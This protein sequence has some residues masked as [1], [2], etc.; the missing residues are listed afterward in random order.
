MPINTDDKN[1]LEYGLA[2]TLGRQNLFSMKELREAA[3]RLEDD[4]LPLTGDV[5]WKRVT[6]ERLFSW[7]AE[8]EEIPLQ[9]SLDQDQQLRLAALQ[10]YQLGH[11]NEAIQLW[12]S[13]ETP[14]MSL[15]V[16]RLLAHAYA[17]Q[18]SL[19]ADPWVA[20]LSL[21]QPTDAEF[22]AALLATRSG[23]PEM[24]TTRLVAAW[25]GCEAP[26]V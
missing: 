6:D 1:I 23:R 3:S 9:L 24:A 13:Q 2:R 22:L 18:G 5:D 8:G 21:I 17:E 7:I 19:L 15:T 11:M 4:R 14:A 16:K 25:S 12:E 26:L 20:R 10:H